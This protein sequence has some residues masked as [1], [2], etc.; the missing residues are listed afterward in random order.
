MTSQHRKLLIV[1]DDEDLLDIYENILA[2]EG[3][4]VAG[5][6]SAEEAIEQIR[7]QGAPDVIL[8]DCLMRRTSGREVILEVKRHVP[9][10]LENS[11]VFMFTSL[12]QA[13]PQAQ[14]MQSVVH[15][16]I[17]KPIDL[18]EFLELLGAL[19]AGKADSRIHW[20]EEEA[21]TG[22][23]SQPSAIL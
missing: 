23:A 8:V 13:S 22:N 18:Y 20:I 14:E 12:N 7:E 4:D 9:D 3:Y 15:G 10:L 11:R 1:D 5:V 17:E 21:P 6:A 16:Y 2:E 19:F